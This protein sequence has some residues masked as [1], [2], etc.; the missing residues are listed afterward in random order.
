MVII[1][2]HNTIYSSLL[3]LH[4]PFFTF[5]P[6]PSTCHSASFN[7]QPYSR[8]WSLTSKKPFLSYLICVKVRVGTR[9]ASSPDPLGQD[10]TPVRTILHP[11]YSPP[12]LWN[13][14][15]LVILSQPADVLEA[16]IGLACM[17]GPG[18]AFLLDQ[19]LVAGWGEERF[20]S[21]ISSTLQKTQVPLV[22]PQAC[23][24]A[25]RTTKLGPWFQLHSSF[26]CAG[27]V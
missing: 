26:I 20:H 16:N 7:F 13:D 21:G 10:I 1:Q 9:E 2:N 15:G 14:L 5:N 19:C 11:L 27:K 4:S 8:G 24:A 12:G 25:L 22:D 17:P 6:T 3:F 23:R 18:D